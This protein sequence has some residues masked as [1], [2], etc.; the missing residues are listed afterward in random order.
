[1]LLGQCRGAGHQ[2]QHLIKLAKASRQ[3]HTNIAEKSMQA[4]TMKLFCHPEM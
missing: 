1:M 2:P 3:R 4:L